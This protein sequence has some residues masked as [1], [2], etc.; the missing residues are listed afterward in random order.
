VGITSDIMLH[1]AVPPFFFVV[2]PS[3]RGTAA[4][5]YNQ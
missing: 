4:F 5:S 1:A 3:L 2:F